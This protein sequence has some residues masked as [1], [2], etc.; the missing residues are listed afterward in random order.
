MK[1]SCDH[2]SCYHNLSNCKLTLT[3]D[4]QVLTGF[5]PLA[6]ITAAVQSYIYGDP[7]VRPD[8]FISSCERKW[9]ISGVAQW[10]ECSPPTNV[11]RLRF[12]NPASC[13]LS[14]FL[15]LYSAPKGFSPVLLFSLL[16]INTHFQVPIRSWNAQ[17]SL[18]EFLWAWCSVG[19]QIALLF[20]ITFR[21][22]DVNCGG[23]EDPGL[24]WGEYGDFLG[25]LQQNFC[26]CGAE[27]VGS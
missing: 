8:Q 17:T 13:G 18:N 10:W 6:C 15:A 2:R 21:L 20:K 16:H 24:M 7:Y 14:L 23:G 9:Q 19:K 11:S 4:F 25:T 22:N 27:N 1:W 12:P 5:G 26:P 3:K